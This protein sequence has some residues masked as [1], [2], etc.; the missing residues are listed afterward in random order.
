MKPIGRIRTLKK[1]EGTGR[2]TRVGDIPR[3]LRPTETESLRDISQ[4]DD[5]VLY[6][7]GQAYKIDK[8]AELEKR[9]VDINRVYG[10]VHERIFFRE[11]EKRR[12][13]HGINFLFQASMEGAR[14]RGMR[15]GG[16][17]LGGIVVDFAFIDRP[18]VV[19]VQGGFWH[20]FRSA[21]I[22]D[23]LQAQRLNE[24]GW[25]VR[26]IEDYELESP[27]LTEAWMRRNVDM[28]VL[29][30]IPPGFTPVVV[31]YGVIR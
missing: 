25:E 3:T 8:Q 29:G 27:E 30:G 2:F 6:R 23:N 5:I 7:R 10:S 19:Q 9:A 21:E 14:P 16:R 28:K 18:M 13:K 15:A 24:R 26:F 1:R 4:D 11:L 22:R 31:G 12:L 20:R 17:Q